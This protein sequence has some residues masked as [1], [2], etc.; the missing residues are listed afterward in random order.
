MVV[1]NNRIIKQEPITDELLK[2][3]FLNWDKQKIK[4]KNRLDNALKWMKQEGIV[5]NGWG[6]V[7]EKAESKTNKK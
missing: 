5:P 6:K 7:I 2:E 3:D 4:Y 1:W